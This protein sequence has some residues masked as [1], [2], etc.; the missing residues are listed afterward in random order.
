MELDPHNLDLNLFCYSRDLCYIYI[1][2]NHTVVIKQSIQLFHQH[3]F[4]FNLSFSS[5]SCFY[6]FSL[7]FLFS[8]RFSLIFLVH[9]LVSLQRL[10]RHNFFIFNH[11]N[12]FSRILFIYIFIYMAKK[13]RERGKFFEL[14]SF[15]MYKRK[16][17]SE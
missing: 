3:R 12:C 8:H 9:N 5:S 13:K 15:C 4:P 17:K 11:F 1:E 2:D 10:Q 16:S 14:D 7:W 6:I